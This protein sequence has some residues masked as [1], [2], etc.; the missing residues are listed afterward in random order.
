VDDAAR[1]SH[2]TPA[3]LRLAPPA[4]VEIHALCGLSSGPQFL[5]LDAETAGNQPRTHERKRMRP[6]P[7]RDTIDGAPKSPVTMRCAAPD[8]IATVTELKSITSFRACSQSSVGSH[9]RVPSLN[10]TE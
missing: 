7:W 5:T 10:G 3:H 8:P 9:V 2:R 4:L 6:V 1:C